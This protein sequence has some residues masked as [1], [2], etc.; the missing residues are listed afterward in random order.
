MAK[1]IRKIT[2]L[3]PGQNYLVTLKAKN[4]ELSALDNAYPAIRFLTPTDS[5]IPSAIDND[6]FFIYA[7][8]KSVMFDFEPT[9]D[10]DVDKY[11]YELYADAAG[12]NLISSGT[13]TA[14]V[15][16]VDVP[17]NSQMETDTDLEEQ[18]KYYGR[19]KTVDTSGNESGWTPSSGLKESS[20]TQLI[21]SAHIRNL[22]ASKITAGTINAHEIILKQQGEQTSI[23][24]P[25]NMAILR[26]S[27]YNGSYN[28]STNQWSSGTSGWVIAGN[29]YAEFSTTSIRGGL[30]AESVFIN[31]DNRWR[32]NSTNTDSSLEFKVG[33]SSK[34]LLFDGTDITFS[35]NLSAAGGTF[36]GALSGGTISIGSGNS[37]FKADSNGIYLGNSTFASA[38]FRVT[39]D[40]VLTANNA[41]ITGTINATSGTFTG[42]LSGANGSFTGTLATGSVRVG[43]EAIS[44]GS[45]EKG[46]SIQASGLS[47]WNNAWIQRADNSVYFRAGNDTR[48]I[49]LDTSGTNEIEFPNFSVDND[50]LLTANN[51]TITGHIN[52]TSGTFSG[53]LQAAGGTF[54]GTLN[55]V[56]GDFTGT[57]SAN[58]ISGGTINGVTF[59]ARQLFL[60]F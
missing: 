16:T 37:I 12:T 13:A 47:Q 58:Q 55:G 35:G 59:N 36:T 4:T 31:A 20:P 21:E 50:G 17:N 46:I 23:S 8:Y 60:G 15:F 19:I 2:G 29:G 45:S 30:R 40:G 25:A 5:T 38:P 9:T 10:V 44:S 22:K 34:Y 32:R 48:Y 6:T 57:I 18:V 27:D 26:S 14:S 33:S 56:G 28:N 52:A 3:K 11:K 54:T 24:A 43:N 49:R 53:D 41:T 42:T 39:P 51:A 7:N 1:I